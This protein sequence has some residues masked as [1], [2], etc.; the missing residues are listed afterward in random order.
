MN[1]MKSV[2]TGFPPSSAA[3]TLSPVWR[4]FT[5][6]LVPSWRLTVEE[7]GKQPPD[8]AAT[9]FSVK[10]KYCLVKIKSYQT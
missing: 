1:I 3:S 9:E 5:A 6:F 7:P 10:I 4:S 2:N 8:L